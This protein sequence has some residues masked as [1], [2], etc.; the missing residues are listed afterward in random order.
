MELGQ[1]SLNKLHPAKSLVQSAFC[2]RASQ[3]NP[4]TEPS[5]G[6]LSGLTQCL[7][8]PESSEK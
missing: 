1:I 2:K 5:F 8:R 3:D 4:D 6:L 7:F